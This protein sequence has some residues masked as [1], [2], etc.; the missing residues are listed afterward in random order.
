ML[1]LSTE[2]PGDLGILMPLV[3]NLLML[4]TGQAFFMTVD[5][6][7]AYLRGDILECMACSN[8]VVRC[9]LTPK[10]RDVDLLVDM[11]SYN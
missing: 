4:K 10:F 2:Y 11:L 7:H 5:E 6:P 9:A 3:L 1:R 8:N